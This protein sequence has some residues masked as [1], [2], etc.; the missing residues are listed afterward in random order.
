MKGP[1]QVTAD[2]QRRL[3]STWHLDAAAEAASWPHTV[4]LGRVSGADL[5]AGF[6][7][8]RR[9]A[10]EIRDWAAGNGLNVSIETRRVLGTPQQIPTNV[11]VPDIDTAVL[12]AG[13]VWRERLG[14]GRARVPILAQL[15]PGLGSIAAAV[16]SVDKY[17]DQDF[18]LLNMA[19]AWFR[20][21]EAHGM[22]PRQ[23]PIPGLH[24]KWLNSHG[25][26][27]RY[28][29]GRT[30]LGLLPRHPSRLHFT[31]LDPAYLAAGGR[32]HDSASTGDTMTPAY[33]PSVVV[34]AENKDT[35]IHFPP[36]PGGIAV[37]GAGF[38][39]AETA[40]SLPW[41]AGCPAIF[42]W[43]DMDAAA[44][45]ILHQFRKAGVAADSVLMDVAAYEAYRQFGADTDAAGRALTAPARK[46][47]PLL[48]AAEENLYGV[49]TDPEWAGPYRVEQERIPLRVGL[50]FIRQASGGC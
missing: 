8:F 33:T 16:R 22:T 1:A 39:G 26:E 10:S 36:V 30:D 27:L 3:A 15:H 17:T 40:G 5:A 9:Q 45:E 29:S 50:Q 48:T 11:T 34:I 21:H 49:L 28:L 4:S 13:K 25:P 23:V 38:S 2:I 7:D 20:E 47:L 35:A 19:A 44:F 14:R 42:Y 41:L 12:V 6:P 18:G 43:G 32:R 31:Y 37:E 24:A 46:T